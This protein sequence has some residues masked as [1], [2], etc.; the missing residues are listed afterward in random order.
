MWICGRCLRFGRNDRIF[1]IQ[2]EV[3]AK[4]AGVT[5]VCAPVFLPPIV[6]DA[7]GTALPQPAE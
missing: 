7:P 1:P 6:D 4:L 2:A 5:G 3:N